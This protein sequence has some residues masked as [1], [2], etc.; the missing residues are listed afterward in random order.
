MTFENKYNSSGV[1]STVE[2]SEI[3]SLAKGA[4][5]VGD[6]SGAPTT[7]T[8]GTNNYVLTYDSA[9][10][11]GVKA[12]NPNTLVKRYVQFRIVASDTDVAVDTVVGGDFRIDF[13]GTINDVRAYVDTPGTT[14]STVVDINI[15]GTSIMTTDKITIETGEKTSE[16]AATQPALT[17][18]SFSAGDIF[19]FDV[20][21]ISTTAPKGLVVAMEVTQS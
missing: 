10:T 14:N 13:G 5:I 12:S 19:T 20:V 17:T 15:G 9:Q 16:D 11:A 6:G 8:A 18:T 1:G 21:S 3:E 2:V 7:V 4:L